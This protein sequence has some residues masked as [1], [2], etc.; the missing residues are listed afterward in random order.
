MSTSKLKEV[1]K[2]R[3]IKQAQLCADLNIPLRTYQAWEQGINKPKSDS[4]I[5]LSDYLGT[6]IDEIMGRSDLP[7]NAIRAVM[8]KSVT[9][10]LYGCIPA[11]EATEM[12]PIDEYLDTLVSDIDGDPEDVFWLEVKGDSMN[13]II[14]D[15][16]YALI[17]RNAE[18]HNGE[19]AAV[20]INGHDATLKRFSRS[21]LK[22]L[23]IPDSTNPIHEIKEIDERDPDATAFRIIGK[24]IGMKA[25]K[26]YRF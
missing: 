10:P 22:V 17:Q 25:P 7:R 18:V 20:N 9:V 3:G 5:V 6:T 1:R 4:L 15:G 26:G 19:I 14:P 11:G 21:G 24:L 23:L 12:L 8:G 13:R 2:S 16:C